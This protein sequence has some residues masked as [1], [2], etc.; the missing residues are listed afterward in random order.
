MLMDSHSND[1]VDS[2]SDIAK[3]SVDKSSEIVQNARETAKGD[4]AGGTSRI[5]QNSMEIAS[6]AVGKGGE[7]LAGPRDDDRQDDDEPY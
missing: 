3:H 2:A 4:L 5:V 7:I 1:R 6:H